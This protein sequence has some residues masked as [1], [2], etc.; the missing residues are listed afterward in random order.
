MMNEIKG[1]TLSGY[2]L[3]EMAIVL[4][5]IMVMFGAILQGREMLENSKIK[6]VI[7]DFENITQAYYA[8]IRRT[9]HAPGLLRDVNGNIVEDRVT[10][11]DFFNDLIAEQL[12][13]SNITGNIVGN[14][15]DGTWSISMDGTQSLALC[16]DNLPAVAARAIDVKLDDG[17]PNTGQVIVRNGDGVII[18]DFVNEVLMVCRLL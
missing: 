5:I 14:A 18:E 4:A 1:K 10:T 6:S 2:T 17:V 11:V 13:V 3:V 16:S 12:I 8:Y 7:N 15:F 9:G